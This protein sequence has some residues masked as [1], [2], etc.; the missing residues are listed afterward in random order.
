M[1]IGYLVS[2]AL[3]TWCA[4]C[5]L[6]PPRPHYSSPSSLSYWFGFLI[7]E[8]PF[9]AFYWLLASTVL[10]FAEGDISSLAGWAVFG[11]A[12]LT[13]A[14]LAVI[15]QRGLQAGSV[16]DRELRDGLGA[17][18]G[19]TINAEMAARLRHHLPWARILFAPLFVW[20]RDVQRIAN[21]RYGGAAKQNLLDL[22]CHRSRP[23]GSPTLV[24]FHGGSFTSGNKNREARPLLYRLASQ[25]WVCVSANYRLSPSARFPDQ[26][27]DAKKVIAWVR[28]HGHDFGADPTV[29]C[30]PR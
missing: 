16:V 27:I 3:V 2:V 10:A 5:A 26:L 28:E 7:N 6:V 19:A 18:W 22:Y 20:R 25:G 4:L 15:A 9:V 24:Y 29:T 14:G 30:H 1:P 21:I 11:L 23:T 13:T 12:V 17:G 8:L